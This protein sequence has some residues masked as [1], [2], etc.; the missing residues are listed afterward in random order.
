MTSWDEGEKLQDNCGILVSDAIPTGRYSLIMG[1]YSASN[2]DRLM[3]SK[4]KD[5]TVL[6]D[7][8][9]LTSITVIN[10]QL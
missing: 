1:I 6:G 10:E 2:G 8:I 3:V 7:A 5:G 4:Y 9:S